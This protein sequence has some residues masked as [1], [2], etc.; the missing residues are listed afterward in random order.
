VKAV[1]GLLALA[2]IGYVGAQERTDPVPEELR[3]VG[4]EEKLDAVLPLHLPFKDERGRDV[5]LGSYFRGGRPVVLTLNYSRCD[6]LCTL[7]LN[8]L[9]A[10]LKALA[11]S[12][13][14]EFEVVT[15]S[16]DPRETPPAAAKKRAGYLR[17][18]GRP[19]AD[20]GWHFLTGSGASIRTLASS[21]GFS[22]EYDP[23]TDQYAHA[24]VIVL[25]T[26]DGRVSRYLYG[27]EFPPDT[28]RLGLLEASEG[29]I[30]SVLDRI[31]LYC[32]H[33]DAERGR[34]GPAARKIMELGGLATVLVL[35]SVLGTFWWRERARGRAR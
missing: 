7:E 21:V 31:L 11:W 15:V 32:Y 26:G 34:Y 6:M 30:G 22:Y 24:A 35:G 33:Y 2:S 18:L 23:A 19:G 13:G 16:I 17:E 14:A 27:V 28:L 10:S 3:R 25:A 29:R 5:T 9:V 8:G 1:A 12:P 20:E 4:V